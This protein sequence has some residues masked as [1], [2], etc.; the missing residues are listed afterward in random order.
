MDNNKTQ[1][2]VE[3]INQGE[4]VNAELMAQ[5]Q[6]L[7]EENARLKAESEK[8]AHDGFKVTDKGGISVYGIQRFPVTL[9]APQWIKLLEK[10]D[11]LRAFIEANRSKL[12]WENP[13]KVKTQEKV[14]A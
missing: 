4:A 13:N 9:Y 1:T 5:L 3:V 12:T 11:K 8:Q 7:R 10:A 14:A 6:A 2:V